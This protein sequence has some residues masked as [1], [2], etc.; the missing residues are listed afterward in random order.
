MRARDWPRL[1]SAHPNWD[2]GPP[3][4]FKRENLKFGLKFNLC[5]SMTSGLIGISS[6]NFIQ[7]TCRELGV[8]MWV[9]FLDVLP[10]KIW[11]GEKCSKSGAI[12]DNFRLSSRISPERIQKSKIGK[13]V[14]QLRPLL[15]S[16]K[17]SWWTSVHKQ[18]S[19]WH[20]Y[21]PT[22]LDIVREQDYISAL[23]WWCALKFLYAL[24][25]AEDLL[26]HTK[27][28]TGVPLPQK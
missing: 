5:T 20:V 25:I 17:K 22:Q 2:G 21:W 11:D 3:K 14:H 18:K 19:Y 13:V 26:T 23:T 1:P 15:R 24:Q 10:P 27:T 6:Q 8:I 16:A 12:S 9:Q 7:T 4:N 28:G